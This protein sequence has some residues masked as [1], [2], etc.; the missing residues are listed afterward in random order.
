MLPADNSRMNSG[1]KSIIEIILTM[2][3]TIVVVVGLFFWVRSVR[4]RKVVVLRLAA[5]AVLSLGLIFVIMPTFRAGGYAQI[6]AL[7]LTVAWGWCMAIIWVPAIT[8]YV[9]GLFGGL[10][11]G[12]TT[13]AEAKP[14]YSVFNSKRSR[15][16]YLEAL[17]EIRRQLGKFPTDFQGMMLL[18]ELQAE[19]LDD[20]PGAEVTIDRLCQ[21]PDHTPLN[22][23]YALNRLADWHL[24][25]TKDRDA[26]QHILEKII[27]R[28]PDT[29]IS[30]RAAQRI[31][32]LA[33]T[34]IL[35]G[36]HDRRTITV[37]KGPENLGLIREQGKL[38]V[39]EPDYA[40]EAQAY[41]DHLQTHPLDN[42]A[43]E[44][45]AELY[46]KHYH[47]IDLAVEQLEQMIGQPTHTAK[48]IVH[49]LNLMADLQV[50]ENVEFEQV[51]TTLQRII[52]GYPTLPAAHNAQRRLDILKFEL[53]SKET[54]KS[55][56]LGTYKQNIGLDS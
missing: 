51:N 26:A 23:A 52:E 33:E 29:E 35:L 37:K 21:Q 1:H 25:V 13:E 45:L 28:F 4:D 48:Q 49:W 31:A 24:S 56:Q 2:L 43:R 55:V 12:G 19:N 38:R 16:K 34:E 32:H 11:D 18:A 41:V 53:K 36:A 17:T 42:H 6:G 9:G 47:R 8:G 39:P 14:F 50:L 22:I 46:A 44:K 3:S 30:Q 20:L 7:F 5:T 10:Y 27:E 40:Q 15:G 54:K